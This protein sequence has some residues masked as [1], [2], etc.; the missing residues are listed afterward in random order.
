MR[1]SASQTWF[2]KLCLFTTSNQGLQQP[3]RIELHTPEHMHLHEVVVTVV[4]VVV[5]VVYHP[6]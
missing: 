6:T 4:V 5:V 3:N 1:S 2:L